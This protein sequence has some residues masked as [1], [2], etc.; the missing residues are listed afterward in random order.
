[1][2]CF[3]LFS[4]YSIHV[5]YVVAG[6]GRQRGGGGGGLEVQQK[7]GTVSET[8][9]FFSACILRRTVQVYKMYFDK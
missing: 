6:P 2:S 7:E 1:M 3:V 8:L 5:Q 4:I 9:G